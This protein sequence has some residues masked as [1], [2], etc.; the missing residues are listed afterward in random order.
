MGTYFGRGVLVVSSPSDLT[1]CSFGG[2]LVQCWVVSC[3]SLGGMLVVVLVVVVL[4]HAVNV[5][6][7]VVLV[8]VVVLV[9]MVVVVLIVMVVVVLCHCLGMYAG[10]IRSM[11]KSVTCSFD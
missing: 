1:W 6:V 9:F 11:S 5:V 8:V 2:L 3:W 10:T 7:L 4:L